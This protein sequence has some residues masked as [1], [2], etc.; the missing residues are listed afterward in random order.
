MVSVV[1][2]AIVA[3]VALVVVGD[4]RPYVVDT[5]QLVGECDEKTQALAQPLPAADL[6]Y[7]SVDS[8][9]LYR[10]LAGRHYAASDVGSDKD[11]SSN[12]PGDASD[13]R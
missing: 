1:A 9:R 12:C 2:L 8:G 6:R 13:T 4:G 7:G 11:V 5:W 3:V 10:G